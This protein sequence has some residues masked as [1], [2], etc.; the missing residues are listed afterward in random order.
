MAG[1]VAGES[2]CGAR[3]CIG[4]RKQYACT[5]NPTYQQLGSLHC[6]VQ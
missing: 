4:M 3:G 5:E 1:P 6:I 2:D